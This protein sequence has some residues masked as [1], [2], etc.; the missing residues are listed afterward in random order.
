MIFAE[1]G[2]DSSEDLNELILSVLEAVHQAD[3]ESRSENIKLGHRQKALEGSSG[4]YNRKCYGYIHNEESE[5]IPHPEQ[6]QVVQQIFEWYLSGESVIGIVKLLEE[7]N[8][9]S[10]RGKTT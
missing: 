3:N 9:P 8:I 4:L 7:N 10:P 2:L 5:L 6:R 1:N